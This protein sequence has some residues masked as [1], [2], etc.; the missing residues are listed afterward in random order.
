[1]KLHLGENI[2]ENRKKLNLTQ[3]QLAN[4]LGVSFQS[5]S[6]W[7]NGTTY[8]D[9][10][11]L[12]E[13]ARLFDTTIDALL[14]FGGT[15][16]KSYY[17]IMAELEKALEVSD[18]EEICRLLRLARYE[19][20]EDFLR[21]DLLAN[22][23]MHP[24]LLLMYTDTLRQPKVLEE[25]RAFSED[26]FENGRENIFRYQLISR[27][28]M[29]EDEE[30]IDDFIS[31]YAS[32]VDLSRLELRKFRYRSLG[33][34][35]KYKEYREYKNYDRLRLFLAEECDCIEGA[36]VR[37][38]LLEEKFSILNILSGIESDENYPVSGNGELDVW[39]GV[40][41][42]IAFDYAAHLAESGQYE[43]AIRALEDTRDMIEKLFDLPK[44]TTLGCRSAL[45][46]DI[47]LEMFGSREIDLI[48]IETPREEGEYPYKN[49]IP[50]HMASLGNVPYLSLTQ[51][52]WD[53][54]FRPIEN[55]PRYQEILRWAERLRLKNE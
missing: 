49:V 50:L 37:L 26:Y 47:R 44:L 7:E 25:L 39:S 52:R 27:M 34:N 31:K 32:D 23:K 6:R 14:G 45:F 12:P 29:L 51:D 5:V 21:G 15:N 20:R 33:M 11:K 30:H 4:R 42:S 24:I 18:E 1:M 16:D 40:R 53:E 36:D 8:P 54:Y 2:R 35:E 46:G 10:E 41:Y 48:M 55:N 38:K 3:E 28:S 22:G 19:Y 13:I 43:K 17:E 9:M